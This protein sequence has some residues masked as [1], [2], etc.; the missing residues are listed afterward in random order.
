MEPDVEYDLVGTPEVFW[1]FETIREPCAQ[2][3]AR[4]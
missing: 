3:L 2:R 4:R 1:P